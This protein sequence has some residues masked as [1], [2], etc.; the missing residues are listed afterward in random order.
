[1]S[2]LKVHTSR[3]LTQGEE[4][5]EGSVIAISTEPGSVHTHVITL[6]SKNPNLPGHASRTG[7]SS[8][9][10]ETQGARNY[11]TRNGS[12]KSVFSIMRV[13]FQV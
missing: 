5:L 10:E 12:L 13:R 7:V 1:M 3:E 8:L 9:S 2:I 11:S 6:G 4:R